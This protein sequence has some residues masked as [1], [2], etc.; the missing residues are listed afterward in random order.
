MQSAGRDE[1]RVVLDPDPRV[2]SDLR[3]LIKTE[4]FIKRKQGPSISALHSQILQAKGVQNV[5]R[6]KELVAR[7]K[8][9]V[10]KS[11]LVIN[12][13][14]IAS[15]SQDALARVTEGFQSLIS[16]T[17]T[18][19][20]LLG[21]A[22]Y[23]EQQVANALNPGGGLFDAEALSKLAEPSS[24]VLSFV[25]RREKLG[26]QV[27]VKTIV[28]SFT[29]KPYGWDLASVEVLL[30]HLIGI[31]KVTLRADGNVLKRSAAANV[32][33]NTQKHPHAVVSPQKTFDDRKVAAFRAF[34]T[35]FFDEGNVPKDPLELAR[36]GADKLKTKRDELKA[37]ASG[38][39]YP[40][41]SQLST[42]IGLLDQVVGKPDEWYLTDFDLG[43]DLLDAKDST[44]DPI[45]A[46]LNGGQKVIYD[47]AAELL[48]THIGNLG[49]L[50]TGSDA[51]VREALK[52]PNAFRGNKMTRLKQT[53]DQ[54]RAQI[55]EVVTSNRD[56]VAGAIEGRKTEL[57]QSAFYAKATLPVRE[58]VLRRVDQAV[59]R[60][61]S[62]RQIALIRGIGSDFEETVYPDLLDQLAASQQ[63]QSGGSGGGG[64]PPP[65]KQTVSVKTIA[66][67]GV[68]GVLE[69]EEDVERYVAA[70][71]AALVQT[72][73]DG[74]RISL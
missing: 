15:T 57:E 50:P 73:N 7:V 21:G 40:F 18:Q 68:S 49:Y 29:A 65:P 25:E 45:R 61:R 62:E 8:A 35:T 20:K 71:R 64:T 16:R 1:L 46:F 44:I 63:G 59:S 10:G 39:T 11:T 30:A 31:S 54:L 6:E 48:T 12:A 41:V 43:D 55:D 9:S 52:D 24:E 47:G 2:I 26:E 19:L 27:T 69:T 3:L 72:L 53:T 33:R 5:D 23:S 58:S 60:V 66:A 32:L 38:S 51:A 36:Y 4:K 17:Y 37:T 70:L 34:C 67:K 22:T 74:K 13:A 14:D 56:H 28:D 42:P